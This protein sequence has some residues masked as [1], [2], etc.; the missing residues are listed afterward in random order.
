MRIDPSWLALNAPD[1][2][3][4]AR[5]DPQRSISFLGADPFAPRAV[6]PAHVI[7]AV[8]D[9]LDAGRTHYSVGNGFMEPTL[10]DSLVR[11]LAS[12]NGMDVDP[13]TELIVVPS[14]AFGLYMSIR[15]CVRPNRGDE[16]LNVDPG[17]AENFNDVQQIG[18]TS[19]SVPVYAEDGYQLR[20]DEV[21]RAITP[22]TRCIVLTNPNNPTG[23]VYSRATLEALAKVVERHDLMVIVDQAFERQV[24]DGREYV[25][26]ATLPGMWERTVTIFG[27]S[28]DLGLSGFRVAYIAARKEIVDVLKLATFNMHGATNTFAQYGVAAAYDNPAYADAWVEVFRQRRAYG[29]RVLDGI[30][31]VNCPLPDGGFYFW[32]DVG[33]L[34]T[35]EFVRDHLI[36][37]AQVGVLPGTMFGTRGSN[38][39]RIM[40]GAAPDEATFTEGIDRIARSLSGLERVK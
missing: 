34:G 36:D 3:P 17:F 39:L 12:F 15:M 19:V 21:E 9:A 37:D 6:L 29:Q 5:L 38:H 1:F 8:K 32:A 27:T 7:D 22:R 40:Y 25:D 26:F 13:E 35:A 14:A 28:K 11:K 16:V 18:A 2:G 30:D 31:G 4:Y 20:A 33:A 24:Y 23:T 10:K